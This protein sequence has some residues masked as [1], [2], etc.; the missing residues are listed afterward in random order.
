MFFSFNFSSM[1]KLPSTASM[2]WKPSRDH[3]IIKTLKFMYSD[4][5]A[6]LEFPTHSIFWK[7]WVKIWTLLIHKILPFETYIV[8]GVKSA[9]KDPSFAQKPC[10]FCKLDVATST[11][12]F[13]FK[14][15][16]PVC[17]TKLHLWHPL[18]Y[19]GTLIYLIYFKNTDYY[20][21]LLEF[22]ILIVCIQ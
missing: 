2:F 17:S 1:A 15:L 21:L 9:C 12:H 8:V 19:R 14:V 10:H 16:R 18:I 11:G 3:E 7:L 4:K 20:P 13:K 22:W 5:R 6:K